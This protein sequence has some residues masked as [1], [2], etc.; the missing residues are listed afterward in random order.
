MI[1]VAT[2]RWGAGSGAQARAVIEKVVRTH[3]AEKAARKRLCEK[4]KEKKKKK[5]VEIPLAIS[6]GARH[7]EVSVDLFRRFGQEVA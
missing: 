1:S 6:L 4:K 5:K 7:G 2:E 3:G